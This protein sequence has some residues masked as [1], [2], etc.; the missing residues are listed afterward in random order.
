MLLSDS[1]GNVDR[2]RAAWQ[3]LHG[4]GGDAR[5]AMPAGYQLTK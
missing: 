5:E 3:A 1:E 2:C 4:G